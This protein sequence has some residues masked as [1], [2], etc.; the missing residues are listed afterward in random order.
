MGG[1]QTARLYEFGQKKP[2]A[3]GAVFFA[4]SLALLLFKPTH[5]SPCTKNGEFRNR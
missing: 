4:L 3:E 1:P 2:H 5:S